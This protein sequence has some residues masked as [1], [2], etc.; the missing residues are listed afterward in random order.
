MKDKALF[1]V[2]H[3]IVLPS[4]S[5]TLNG[6]AATDELWAC[7]FF[8]FFFLFFS[9]VFSFFSKLYF[10]LL[11]SEMAVFYLLQLV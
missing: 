10:D 9:L 6:S 5:F 8:L 1:D 4:R 7:A 11:F 3:L 2:T